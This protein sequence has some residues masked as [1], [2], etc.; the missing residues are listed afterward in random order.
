[1][2]E[3]FDPTEKEVTKQDIDRFLPDVIKFVESVD[4]SPIPPNPSVFSQEE[5]SNRPDMEWL[6]SVSCQIVAPE[7]DNLEAQ[8]LQLDLFLE[9]LQ[10]EA[11]VLQKSFSEIFS[12]EYE[13]SPVVALD[14]ETTGLDTRVMY[15]NGKITPKT[16]ITCISI[17]TSDTNGY[18]L[19][20]LQNQLD[21]IKNWDYSIIVEFLTKLA[22]KFLLVF[23]NAQYDR[24]V[25]S[26][27]GVS[28]RPFPYFLDTMVLHYLMDVNDKTHKLK[29]VSVDLLGRKMIE[30]SQ[31]FTEMGVK[32]KVRINF[33][34][35]CAST[36]LVYA[37]SDAIN[38]LGLL[39][40]F[41]KMQAEDNIFLKQVTPII[42]D[43]KLVDSLR[44]M[45]R[46]GFPVNF[47]Y[48][49]YS[50]K[51]VQHRLKTLEQ[52]IYEFVGRTFNINSTQQVSKIV[53]DDF[54][55]PTL[56]DMERGK[57]TKN[58][59][60]GLFST[61]A[62]IFED[63][64]EKYPQYPILEYI[65]QYRQLEHALSVILSKMV[66]NSYVDDLLPFTRCQV[67]Y[68]TVVAPTGRLSSASNGGREKI[69]VKI[70]PAGNVTYAYYKGDWSAGIN[71]QAISKDEGGMNEAKR[72]VD[73][74]P[75]A[76][77][78]LQTPYSESVEFE[79]VKTLAQ[80]K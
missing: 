1:M 71:T 67:Q 48:A 4:V 44:Q 45:Y 21:G 77:V 76:G 39:F 17:A 5:L 2:S 46:S 10:K 32:S 64:Y 65:V 73:L 57:P 61:A 20:V 69:L 68:S 14:V 38:T 55:V 22:N 27:N 74:P 25:M 51:D 41:S 8:R 49:M 78:N 80:I 72:I 63:L 11:L 58:N 26:I 52:T 62:K 42:V 30:I 53:F 18:C 29:K 37:V 12:K 15:K 56:T 34:R 33:D 60:D 35:I 66:V 47:D 50:C 43:H 13:E 9:H 36:A 24:E 23:H 59:P 31:L 7:T 6:K 75:E 40:Y 70:T 54:K 19:P 28:L 16:I 3:L 79:F